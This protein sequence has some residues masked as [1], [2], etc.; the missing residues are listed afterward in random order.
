[1]E[2]PNPH[3]RSSAGIPAPPLHAPPRPAPP[4]AG[5]PDSALLPPRAARDPRC[6]CNGGWEQRRAGP[7]A[8]AAAHQPPR[9]PQ[10]SPWSCSKR[11]SPRFPGLPGAI[12][13]RAQSPSLRAHPIWARPA[14]IEGRNRWENASLRQ[15]SAY[16]HP[17][18]HTQPH[19][20]ERNASLSVH[21]PL[22]RASWTPER[23]GTCWFF[24]SLHLPSQAPKT[25]R[26]RGV[27]APRALGPEAGKAGAGGS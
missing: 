24:F 17:H 25:K 2:I 18:P 13:T 5:F 20:C 15:N 6:M 27:A 26:S 11:D 12:L 7:S 1:M 19:G 9:L 8:P 14:P 22:P 10:T 4:F 3:P 16:I 23:T 21:P